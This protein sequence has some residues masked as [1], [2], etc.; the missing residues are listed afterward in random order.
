MINMDAADQDLVALA[1][2]CGKVCLP[3]AC[4]TP[5]CSYLLRLISINIHQIRK[6][7]RERCINGT[8]LKQQTYEGRF[9]VVNIDKAAKIGSF[10]R[11]KDCV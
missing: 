1:E 8:K 3:P 4:T 6:K 10:L 2:R 5:D 7:E 11:K 9:F